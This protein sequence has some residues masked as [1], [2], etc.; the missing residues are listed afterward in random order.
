MLRIDR[1]W[2]RLLYF[3]CSVL[4]SSFI[5]GGKVSLLLSQPVID[6]SQEILGTVDTVTPEYEL[7][8]KLYLEN[9][10]TCHIGI[11]PAVL[12]TQSW[13]KILRNPQHYSTQLEPLIRPANVLVANYLRQYSRSAIGNELI[14]LRLRDSRFFKALHPKVEFKQ[15]IDAG[16]CI[17]CHSQASNFNFRTFSE[18]PS[19]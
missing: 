14:P 4:L 9:C 11:P 17:S 10:A 1:W 2:K 19:P 15:P 3:C 16:S 12:P 5:L 7:G 18:Q 6:S 13:F 8:H